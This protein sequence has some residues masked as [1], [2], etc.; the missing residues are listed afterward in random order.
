MGYYIIKA[1]ESSFSAAT[2]PHQDNIEQAFRAIN[3][4]W[5]GAAARERRQ[6]SVIYQPVRITRKSGIKY[7][8]AVAAL[9][10]IDLR[11]RPENQVLAGIRS[12]AK[13]ALEQLTR[14]TFA[15]E[16][17]VEVLPYQPQLNG[18]IDFWTTPNR[19][20]NTM[21]RSEASIT[22]VGRDENPVGPDELIRQQRTLTGVATNL[23]ASQAE[24]M[25][26]RSQAEAQDL[27]APAAERRARELEDRAYR[28]R[29]LLIGGGVAVITIGAIAAISYSGAFTRLTR[30]L[31]PSQKGVRRLN[32]RSGTSKMVEDYG[33]CVER[34]RRTGS[35][36]DKM[37]AVR[38]FSLLSASQRRDAIAAFGKV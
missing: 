36:T 13:R 35:I 14:G 37:A 20:S 16:W 21:T 15:T 34:W 9:A 10:S 4:A 33:K 23:A 25:A 24:V 3:Q 8:T 5:S 18:P 11:G 1:N 27:S 19:A 22:A 38:C 26:A 30:K 2:A 29:M 31:N 6:P 32:P 7:D 12:D 28:Q 17:G